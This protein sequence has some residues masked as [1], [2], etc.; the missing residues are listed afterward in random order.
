[1]RLLLVAACLLSSTLVDW[2]VVYG[3][4]DVPVADL[5]AMGIA[6][7]FGLVLLRGRGATFGALTSEGPQAPLALPAAFGWM[8]FITASLAGCVLAGA[9]SE[10]YYFVAR[11]PLFCWV[12]YG[13]GLAGV[14]RLL[15]AASLRSLGYAHAVW[16]S[17]L[18]LP[19]AVWL[20]VHG[21]GGATLEL[22]GLINNH[23]LLAV[24]LAPWLGALW[25]WRPL[26]GGRL[27]AYAWLILGLSAVAVLTSM[28]KAAWV[29]AVVSLGAFVE[30]RGRPVLARPA[31]S[32]G[33]AGIGIL[34]M[35]ALPFATGGV[36]MIDSFDSRW[37]LNVRAWNMFVEHPLRGWG[38][39][40]ATRWL[41]N[42]PRHYRIDGVDAH[43]VI[44]KVAS[45]N[46]LLGL[47]AY[48][49]AYLWFLRY[50]WRAA[51]AGSND[52]HVQGA[53]LLGLGLQ[54]NLLL[55]TDYFSSAHWGSLAIAL[56]IVSRDPPPRHE[57]DRPPDVSAPV[58]G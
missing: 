58:S 37:S 22:E 1:M 40:T 6:G 12:V 18:I 29:T 51:T 16:L 55:S 38:P 50:F 13:A 19:P 27:G 57:L 5:L 49:L 30:W 42:D 4:V 36:E 10:M 14:I 45:E 28:S 15:P 21:H 26:I 32:A 33:L 47:A 8:A 31:L 43:G 56:G 9:D 54:L 20:V 7:S 11:K 2:R 48:L 25:R 24:A 53:A 35:I 46:G 34:T 41:M 23:K 52:R 3:A 44:Q 39:G 17:G